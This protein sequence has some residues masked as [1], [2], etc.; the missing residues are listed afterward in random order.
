MKEKS[1]SF[2]DLKVPFYGFYKMIKDEKEMNSRLLDPKNEVIYS[3]FAIY[4]GMV[5]VAPILFG[6]AKGLETLIS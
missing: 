3:G 6:L 4:Q 1:Y 2:N 5:T